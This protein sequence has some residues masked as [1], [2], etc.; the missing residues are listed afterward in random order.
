MEDGD[1]GGA[2]KKKQKKKTKQ[3][4]EGKVRGGEKMHLLISLRGKDKQIRHLWFKPIHLTA[5]TAAS[6]TA[7]PCT[8]L[9]PSVL[10]NTDRSLLPTSSTLICSLKTGKAVHTSFL[11]LSS[12]FPS[13]P[14]LFFPAGTSLSMAGGEVT[15]RSL[16][17]AQSAPVFFIKLYEMNAFLVLS[18]NALHQC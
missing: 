5:D 2:N 8:D 13:V 14:G 12:P 9:A 1:G 11:H 4:G 10:L 17:S 15:E 3:K 7:S 16:F 6:R 18:H